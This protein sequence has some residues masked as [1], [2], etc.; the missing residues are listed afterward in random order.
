MGVMPEKLS[1][2]VAISALARCEKQGHSESTLL[3]LHQTASEVYPICFKTLSEAG[4]ISLGGLNRVRKTIGLQ[5]KPPQTRLRELSDS[6]D[7][8]MKGDKPIVRFIPNPEREGIDTSPPAY[9]LIHR[10]STTSEPS[11]NG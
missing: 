5:P 3:E 11:W 4:L 7:E 6:L 10:Q 1:E 8:L 9:A 2:T